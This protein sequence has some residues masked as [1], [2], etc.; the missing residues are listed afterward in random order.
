MKKGF[1]GSKLWTGVI[2]IALSWHCMCWAARILVIEADKGKIWDELSFT[3]LA[4]II[5]ALYLL[6]GIILV[7]SRK[8]Q[9]RIYA[10]MILVCFGI[11]IPLELFTLITD[12]GSNSDWGYIA[13]AVFNCLD[14]FQI[15]K[16]DDVYNDNNTVEEND[17]GGKDKTD[18]TVSAL[19]GAVGGVVSS[20]IKQKSGKNKNEEIEAD[21]TEG[22]AGED[23]DNMQEKIENNNE[24]E[25]EENI[26]ESEEVDDDDDDDDDYDVD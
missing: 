14:A 20:L 6:G 26:E 17:K 21:E 16:N 7:V 3:G 18:L 24:K 5:A 4:F 11:V 8:S 13:V 9:E 23:N 15:I 25:L 10:E 2:S 22:V 12:Y 1:L 19:A